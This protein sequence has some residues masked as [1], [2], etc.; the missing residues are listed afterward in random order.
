M[1]NNTPNSIKKCDTEGDGNC[2]FHAVFGEKND[3]GN[4]EVKNA[5]AMREEWHNFLSQYTS[6]KDQKM[7]GLLK[8]Q[9]TK[10]F[11]FFLDNPQDLT[12][13]SEQ[14]ATLASE[15]ISDRKQA[16][17]D[18]EQ[19][20][21]NNVKKFSQD[22]SFSFRDKIYEIIK[23]AR[24]KENKGV[25]TPDRLRNDENQ[26][27]NEVCAN[28]KDCALQYNPD[29]DEKEYNTKYNIQFIVGSFLENS[30]LY[31]NYLLAIKSHTYYILFEEIPIIA[32]LAN[33]KVIIHYEDDNGNQKI[34]IEPNQGLINSG[35]SLHK[36]IWGTKKEAIIFHQY[37]HFSHAEYDTPDVR[38]QQ[39]TPIREYSNANEETTPKSHINKLSNRFSGMKIVNPDELSSSS[40]LVASRKQ[41]DVSYPENYQ[42]LL[43]RCEYKVRFEGTS[44][45]DMLESIFWGGY[46][47]STSQ[48]GNSDRVA[49]VVKT[50][51]EKTY[52][53]NTIEKSSSTKK[54]VSPTK[55]GSIFSPWRHDEYKKIFYTKLIPKEIN[56]NNDTDLYDKLL[57]YKIG[58][59][60]IVVKNFS[61]LV[62]SD[63]KIR[64]YIENDYPCIMVQVI[65]FAESKE[66][67]E[68]AS[69]YKIVQAYFTAITN[70]VAFNLKIPIELVNRA[71]FGH[72]IPS[73]S[74]TEKS[75][76][77]SIGIVPECY[78]EVLV[79]SLEF[80]ND[81]FLVPLLNRDETKTMFKV[82][83]DPEKMS[84]DNNICYNNNIEI[85]KEKDTKRQS[86]DKTIIN[87]KDNSK[88]ES[89]KEGDLLLEV[90]CKVGDS[91]G[92]KVS[93]QIT[94]CNRYIELLCDYVHEYLFT[95][96]D[97]KDIAK[98][99]NN[100]LQKIV[101]K[102]LEKSDYTNSQFQF[103][104]EEINV[105]KG[106][107]K[108]W[109]IIQNI[110]SN[111]KEVG[112]NHLSEAINSK[113]IKGLYQC[114]EKANLEFI[115]NSSNQQSEDGYGSSSDCEIEFEN[116]KF[117]SKKV[118]VATGM[119]ATSL[120]LFLS[121][122]QVGELKVDTKYMY[123]E[124][125]CVKDF[126]QN[127]LSEI[128]KPFS[129]G[130]INLSYAKFFPLE[131][132]KKSKNLDEMS[133]G[134]IKFIDLN[135]CAA[136]GTNSKV[137]LKEIKNNLKSVKMI[138]LDYTSA[139][140]DKISEAIQLFIKEVPV[141]LLVSSG[142]K[143]EQ[144]GADMNPY[145]TLRILA[146][147]RNDL[148]RLYY[149]LIACL[150]SN[151][152]L[153]RE[154][155]NIRR[156]YKAIG[157]SPTSKR[158]YTED[159][160]YCYKSYTDEKYGHLAAFIENGNKLSDVLKIIIVLFSSEY[161]KECD[162]IKF[163]G[164]HNVL[165]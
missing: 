23:I 142:L 55:S 81:K 56:K 34:E 162:K 59:C 61:E 88:V 83:F 156:A 122:Y 164:L 7:T 51:V 2:F 82:D 29:L 65:Q 85:N 92:R 73:V 139:T 31:E 149:T 128:K 63:K 43:V 8:E 48:G 108:F 107:Q 163:L 76:R 104:N 75:F 19:L 117:Y 22:L 120:A 30:T 1:S 98:P 147:D 143:N 35:Y 33:I 91:S 46:F 66:K 72:N 106:D 157:A 20:K 80:L 74:V 138:V 144:I 126:V 96:D 97:T 94:R 110:S 101:S 64:V 52:I 25:L 140:T 125:H 3:I 28:L 150:G 148:N 86:K 93:F 44:A 134:V 47:R 62:I 111:F 13:K 84:D 145:G 109:K 121:I 137:D 32:S 153:P 159:R 67:K 36:E 69:L 90:L 161:G 160:E 53:N 54:K 135:Y 146:T 45:F 158:L 49:N 79:K 15:A 105:I 27:L 50:K 18:V 70:K 10:I 103:S 68:Q 154:S 39:C 58:I 9:L 17:Q 155:H 114:L 100:I 102:N 14:I 152:K 60:S 119:K 127:I 4:Y 6:L 41:N 77:I 165:M 141:L 40:N 87:T 136:K 151:E 112:E 130:H 131:W 78:A 16:E 57:Q 11:Q 99:L 116:I 26:L 113:K 37:D 132:E 129:A 21:D 71:S 115:R 95:T 118:T 12:G 133:S 5:N 89:W 38:N 124:T 123:Y 24:E 42:Y